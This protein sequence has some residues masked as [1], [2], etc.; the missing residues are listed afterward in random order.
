MITLEEA[1]EIHEILIRDFGGKPG[2]KDE[3]VLKAA[4]AR[5]YTGLSSNEFYPT[6]EEKAAAILESI[7]AGHPFSDGNKRTG[8]VLMRLI[9]M[10][11]NRDIVVSEEL[12]YQFV[13]SVASSELKFDG[14][15]S[16]LKENVIVL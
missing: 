16:W 7:V 4:L 2:I 13:I 9:L 6:P 12:K 1:L 5:P 11:Y 14:I 3:N 10:H 15:V 8:Y